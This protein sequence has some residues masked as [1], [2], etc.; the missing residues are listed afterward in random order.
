MLE[1]VHKPLRVY[2]EGVKHENNNEMLKADLKFVLALTNNRVFMRWIRTSGFNLFGLMN[3]N[4]EKSFTNLESI[5]LAVQ[6]HHNLLIDVEYSRAFALEKQTAASIFSLD[7]AEDRWMANVVILSYIT[8]AGMDS[9]FSS[10]LFKL[11]SMLFKEV[12]EPV[13]EHGKI[14]RIV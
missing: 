8:T 11:N 1:V 4:L 6:V 10:F 5:D 12:E 14:N 9:H 2:L 3:H 7:M 13:L